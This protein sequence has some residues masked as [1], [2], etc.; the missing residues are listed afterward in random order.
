M[1]ILIKKMDV[2][3]PYLGLKVYFENFRTR[4]IDPEKYLTLT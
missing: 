1:R 2:N 3:R 4:A